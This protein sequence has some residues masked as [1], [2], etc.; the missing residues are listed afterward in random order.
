[1]E[2]LMELRYF[3]ESGRM[4]EAMTLLDEMD[5][6]AK[7]DKINKIESFLAVLLLHLIKQQAEQRTTRSWNISI[8]NATHD[9]MRSWKR[10]KVKGY[11]LTDEEMREAI[12]EA[13]PTAL[14]K[15][16]LEAFGGAYGVKQL[17]SMI[18]PDRICGEA[19]RLLFNTEAGADDDGEDTD[20]D[21]PQWLK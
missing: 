9:I 10:R 21:I 20:T 8:R 7:D 4:S 3:I 11:Y 12:A 14:N 18:A 5:E 6:M 1:M 2:E 19:A 13:F 15:A 17:S 16:A